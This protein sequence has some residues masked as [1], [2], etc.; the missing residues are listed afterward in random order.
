MQ[1]LDHPHAK[2]CVEFLRADPETVA[3]GCNTLGYTR[4]WG[5][6]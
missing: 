3:E 1:L 6:L 2:E 5:E 4:E